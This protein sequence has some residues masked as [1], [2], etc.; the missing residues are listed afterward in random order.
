MELTFQYWYLLPASIVIA[1]IAM[2]SGVGG[3]VFF[4]PLFILVLRLEPGIAIGAALATEFFGFL[5]GVTAY[6]RAKLIDYNLAGNLLIFSIPGAILGTL[7]GGLIHPLVLKSLFSTGLIFIGYQLFISQRK[8]ERLKH[9]HTRLLEYAESY[10]SILTD[11]KGKVYHYTVCNKNMG[12]TF[13]AIGGAFLGIISVGLAELQDYQLVARCKVPAPIA[14][15]TSIFVVVITVLVAS[16]GHFYEFFIAGPEVLYK[17]LGII[18]FTAP[19]VVIG[20][21]IG[22]KLQSALPEDK[23]K[24]AI[25]LLFIGIGIFM[26]TTLIHG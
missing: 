22:A 10:E 8:E 16:L 18:I 13:A 19:G 21:Q 6:S 9:E 24:V 14:V 4:S 7:Y 20:G 26:L 23:M 1:T 15:G 2:S 12:R 25:S 5:S 11:R 3:A 17:V